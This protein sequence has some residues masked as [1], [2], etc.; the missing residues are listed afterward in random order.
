MIKKISLSVA[1]FLSAIGLALAGGAYQGL[2][3]VG[4][5][6][7]SN[8]LSYGNNGVCNQYQPAG[9]STLTGN[10]TFPA[11]T[12]IQGGGSNGAGANTVSVPV[13]LFGGGYGN[14][15]IYS[16]TGTTAAVTVADGVSDF[17]Y[18]GAG[19][20]TFTSF[21]LNANPMNNQKTCLT[22]AGTG[23]LTL[24][25][26]SASANSYGNT[27]TIVGVTPTSIPVMTAVGTA[28][29]VTLG[30]NCWTYVGGANNTGIWYRIQ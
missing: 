20:A 23:V 14:T 24:T 13:S 11:D 29:T 6:G 30:S 21:S 16:T 8:C 10:E 7:Q 22:N 2:P 4:G 25:A 27:P 5:N 17:I 3:L 15:T 28:G 9:P 26:V 12:N 1:L 19:T 18:T